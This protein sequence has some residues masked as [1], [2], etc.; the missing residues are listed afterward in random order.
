MKKYWILVLVSFCAAACE[1]E[2]Y[3][4]TNLIPDLVFNIT[5]DMGLPQY[6]QLLI[7]NGWVYDETLG[8]RGI[9]I[10]TIN[11]IDYY[12]YDAGCPHQDCANPMDMS[13]FPEFF[14]TCAAD[15]IFYS[16]EFPAYS[17]TYLKDEEGN[18]MALP[19]GQTV[20]D[21]QQYNAERPGNGNELRIS[22]FNY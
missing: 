1:S 7:P 21:M 19:E 3:S 4:D 12:A 15:G 13:N 22:N 5:I 18:R 11:A 17:I 2:E 9:V 16:I 14:N 6:Q 10:Y 20:Y 8:Y